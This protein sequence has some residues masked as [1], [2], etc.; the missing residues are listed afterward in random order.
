MINILYVY[1]NCSPHKYKSLIE[2]TGIMILQQAQK[3]HQLM[4]EGLSKNDCD[5]LAVSSLPVN[6]QLTKKLFFK[7]KNDKYDNITYKYLAFINLPILR[8]ISI[9]FHSL[10]FCL[11]KKESISI[12]DIL[13]ISISAGA[14]LASKIAGNKTVG[15]VTDVPGILA[16]GNNKKVPLTQKINRWILSKFDAYLFLT[17][18]M[19]TL[20][21]KENRP[22]VIIEGQVDIGMASSENVLINKF[23]KKVCV[24]SGSLKS[25]YGIEILVQAFLVA[26][27]ENS[28]LHIY[29]DGD[30]ADE[31][32]NISKSNSS[33]K[34][35]GV[36]PNNCIVNEQLKAILLINP[37]PTDEEYTKYSFPSKNMEYMASGTATLTTKLP[38]MPREYDEFVYLIEDETVEGLSRIIREVLSKPREELHEKGLK[39]KEFVL[40]EKNN[41]VQA[42]KVLDMIE[43]FQGDNNVY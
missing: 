25:I 4:M 40:R 39:A 2:S 21:N 3:Y 31:L 15:I 24:Y 5:V 8:N 30:F 9:F 35:F 18:Q 7:A 43:K 12:C 32:R 20:I 42:K 27:V 28:E 34:Y 22:Y 23:D 14:L 33:I 41:I 37:R 11:K 29:G 19:N 38:G 1:S 17:E 36:K 10:C 26:N 13:N 16:D 6:R